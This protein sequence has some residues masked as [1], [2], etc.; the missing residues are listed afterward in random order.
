[1]IELLLAVI[2][3]AAPDAGVDP[4]AP[5]VSAEGGFSILFPSPPEERNEPGGTRTFSAETATTAFIVSYVEL[6]TKAGR[7]KDQ[8]AHVRETIAGGGKLTAERP[9][10]LGRSPGLELV[11]EK[12]GLVVTERAYVIGRRLY[13]LMVIAPPGEANARAAQLFFGSF[14]ALKVSKVR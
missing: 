3:T 7:P 4:T 1:M 9:V 11:V 8:L 13:Q 5:F 6:P 2:V 12:D 14:K 10:T